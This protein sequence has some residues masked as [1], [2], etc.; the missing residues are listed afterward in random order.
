M[1]KWSILFVLALILGLL[2]ACGGTTDTEN[3]DGAVETPDTSTDTTD[4]DT[5][6]GEDVAGDDNRQ[7]F[8][9]LIVDNEN[10]KATLVDVIR[11]KDDIFGDEIRV[12]FEVENKTDHPIEVQARQVSADGKMI[13]E[14]ILSMST[15]VAPGKIAD[16]VL[17]IS[18]YEGYEFPALE[19]NLEM[20]LHIFSWENEDFSEDHEVKVHFK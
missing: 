1:K 7:E 17:T 14:T 2:T 4:E 19:D 3:K 20:I 13:D 18:D 11:K 10:V 9:Q 12:K 6:V 16:A 5:G 15:E 8:N